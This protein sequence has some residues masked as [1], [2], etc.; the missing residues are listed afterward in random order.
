MFRPKPAFSM[1][2]V[3]IK[4]ISVKRLG[5]GKFF[6]R[7]VTS[8]HSEQLIKK[9]GHSV[10]FI[11]IWRVHLSSVWL[12][13]PRNTSLNCPPGFF[14]SRLYH[15]VCQV[16]WPSLSINY[17]CCVSVLVIEGTLSFYEYTCSFV[18][19]LLTCDIGALHVWRSDVINTL[20]L[21]S[22]SLTASES[23]NWDR[24]HG[25]G[26]YRGTTF[27]LWSVYEIASRDFM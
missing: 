6:Y 26:L 23:G 18:C 12:S 8:W 17:V 22:L 2:S 15:W 16:G 1:Y 19:T 24:H 11:G 5:L 3:L 9:G 25:V 14:V 10:L 4:N 20:L 13:L 21:F 27:V 7:K